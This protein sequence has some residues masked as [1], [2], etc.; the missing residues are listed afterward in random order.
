MHVIWLPISKEKV[1]EELRM[2]YF[3]PDKQ[4]IVIIGDMKNSQK[5]Q[6]RNMV[7][8]KLKSVLKEINKKYKKDIASKIM[9]TLG[10][11][12]QGIFCSGASVLTIIEEIQE[13]M[14]SIEIRFGIGVGKITTRV[15]AKM[16]IGADG[17]GFYNARKAI[18]SLKA[19]EQ[20]NKT[21]LAE[22]RIEIDEDENNVAMLIN[23]VFSLMKVIKNNWTKRQREIIQELE[24]SGGNQTECAKRL[25]V[26][27]STINR[28]LNSGNFYAYKNAK[29]TIN[30]VLKEMDN[31]DV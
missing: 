7:Q 25:G 20:K 14:E 16:A 11:E 26:A 1:K 17:P 4:Y 23:T 22:A 30:H 5:I 3:S 27:Q 31:K 8:E 12:F 21:C 29:E 19:D 15:N 28:G 10:D 18:E 9:I 24:K 13:G 6:D 2:F